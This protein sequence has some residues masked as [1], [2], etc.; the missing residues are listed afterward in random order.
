MHKDLFGTKMAQALAELREEWSP[1]QCLDAL[2]KRFDPELAR[3]GAH[4]FDLRKRC[5]SRIGL[6]LLPYLCEP[7]ASQVTAP[8]IARY[9]AQRIAQ[10][11]P[12]SHIW[13]ATCGLGMESIH[14]SRAGLEVVAGDLRLETARYARANLATHGLPARVVCAD[15]VGSAVRAQGQVL[16]PDRRPKGSRTMDSK[17]W[18]PSLEACLASAARHA[19]AAIKLPPAWQVPPAW[20]QIHRIDWISLGGELLECCLWMGAW[21]DAPGPRAV[22]IDPEGTQHT[23]GEAPIEVD[24]LEVQAAEAIPYLTDPD[25]SLVRSGL[26]GSFAQAH[27]MAPLAPHL[28]Y[29]GADSP[30]RSP[31]GRTFRVLASCPLDTKRVRNMLAQFDVGPIQVRLR[32]HQ[33]RPEAL[34]RRLAGPGSQPGHIAIARLDPHRWVYLL[35]PLETQPNRQLRPT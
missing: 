9:R 7:N 11:T 3:Q 27:G 13:D 24:P 21:A 23:F 6:D 12:N 33:E 30:L 26:L 17:A 16:D 31:F 25:P 28:G 32:G 14:L 29:L 19:S 20:L 5:K 18:S 8:A 2:R 15:A 34:A 1:L 35:E 10:L 22:V 4:L